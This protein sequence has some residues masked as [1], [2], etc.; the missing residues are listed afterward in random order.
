MD[1][2]ADSS[3]NYDFQFDSNRSILSG[4]TRETDWSLTVIDSSQAARAVLWFIDRNGNYTT[5]V[6]TYTPTKPTLT[7]NDN[8]YFGL[9]KQRQSVSKKFTLTNHTQRNTTITTITLQSG[10]AGFSIENIALPFTMR[11]GDSREIT[12]TFVQ[13]KD[14]TYSDKIGLGDTCTIIYPLQIMAMVASPIL[15]VVDHDFNTQVLKSQTSWFDLLVKNTGRVDA[16]ITGDDHLTALKATPEFQPVNWNITYPFILHPGGNISFQ[17]DYLPTKK[18]TSTAQITFSS[19]AKLKDS[20]CVLTATAIDTSTVG[21]NDG[22]IPAMCTL[23]VSP[24]PIGL[25]GGV[26]EFTMQSHGFAELTLFT[27]TGER[28]ATLAQSEYDKGKY[29][30]RIPVE[31]LSSGSY[32]V[33]MVVGNFSLEKA[34]VIVK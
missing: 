21:V 31:S 32:I 23:N 26:V 24:N 28:V 16:V 30:V 34:V 19:D 18:G 4:E 9:L 8:L 29:Q 13:S 12:V 17:I 3:Y 2:N 33:R 25:G 6:F 7:S 5:S 1:L 15:E 14:S 22:H 27:S 11:P 20:V 10:K